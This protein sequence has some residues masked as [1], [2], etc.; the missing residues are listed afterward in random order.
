MG[1]INDLIWDIYEAE[2]RFEGVY[3]Y[4][5][6]IS[7]AQIE[8]V[9]FYEELTGQR[10]Y[11]TKENMYILNKYAGYF[12]ICGKFA[13]VVNITQAYYEA[14][15]L[16]QEGNTFEAYKKISEFTYGAVISDIV[17]SNLSLFMATAA[18]NPFMTVVV[19]LFAA[20]V[21]NG[22]GELL[23]DVV[24]DCVKN[25]IEF[26][27]LAGADDGLLVRD[28]NGNGNIDNGGELFGDLTQIADGVTAVNGFEAL[29][30]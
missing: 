13:N 4:G 3:V 25:A 27:D 21:A 24:A 8:F 2:K 26:F 16:Y 15:C 17:I 5:E 28:L 23:G 7:E 29:A 18:V 10:F 19:L 22:C 11:V 12:D 14:G 1:S 9:K 30:A 6:P 20:W